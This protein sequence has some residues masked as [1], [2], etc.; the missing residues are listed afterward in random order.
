[1]RL[2]DADH[3]IC[4][5]MRLVLEHL[6]LLTIHIIYGSEKP[7]IMRLETVLGYYTIYSLAAVMD[8]VNIHGIPDLGV[9]TGGINL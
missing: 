6:A 4:A 5:D 7:H 8:E 3:A 2:V 9:G 1:M